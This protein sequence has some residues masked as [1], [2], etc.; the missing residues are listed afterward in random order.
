MVHYIYWQ[1]KTPRKLHSRWL[2]N[3]WDDK[4]IPETIKRR[5]QVD[6]KNCL[7]RKGTEVAW[8]CFVSVE[9]GHK[10]YNRV[11]TCWREGRC[12][13]LQFIIS[14]FFGLYWTWN[15]SNSVMWRPSADQRVSKVNADINNRC[16]L[17]YKYVKSLLRTFALSHYFSSTLSLFSM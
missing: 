1:L 16:F 4:Y 11:N 5:K 14:P 17:W 2:C 10:W 15:I 3:R 7:R 8:S 6:N 9:K 13:C 12:L